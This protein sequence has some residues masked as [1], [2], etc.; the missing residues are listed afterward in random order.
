ML[1]LCEQM[2]LT[3]L[4]GYM[5]EELHHELAAHFTDAEI[6]ELGMTMAGCAGLRSS[7]FASILQTAK[8]PVRSTAPPKQCGAVHELNY[9]YD[10]RSRERVPPAP[11]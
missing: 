1:R 5:T 2:V 10:S 11:R 8:T 9:R 3:N 6:F 7:S 4:H